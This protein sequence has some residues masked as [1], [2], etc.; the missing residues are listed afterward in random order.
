PPAQPRTFPPTGS[1]LHP[2]G[3]LNKCLDVQAAVYANGTPVQIYDCNGTG[4]QKW[5]L[6]K[7]STKILVAGTNYCLD[8]GSAP[9]NGVAMKIWQCYD[10]LAAQQ[11]MY[12]NDN[13]ITLE[14]KG[15]CLDLESGN[16]K[17]GGKVQTWQCSNGNN[18]QVW[19]K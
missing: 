3:N 6:S 14:G 10:N 19:T 16:T 4:A 11:W 2:N 17:N 8:A 5:V 12:G 18:N 13:K 9:A 15:Q 1:A 7:G